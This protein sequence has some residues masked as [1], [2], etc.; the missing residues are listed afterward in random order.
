MLQVLNKKRIS[1]HFPNH[2]ETSYILYINFKNVNCRKNS[3][4]AFNRMVSL[5]DNIH[6]FKSLEQSCKE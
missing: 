3:S 1:I 2:Q 6:R 4:V 5:L